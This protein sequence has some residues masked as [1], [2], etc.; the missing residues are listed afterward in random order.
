MAATLAEPASSTLDSVYLLYAGHNYDQAYAL[1]QRLQTAV[2]KPEERFN[3]L[4]ELGDYYLDKAGNYAAAESIYNQLVRDFPKHKLVP[5]LLYRLALAQE[6]QERHLD[7]ARNYEQVATKHMKSRFGTDALDAIERCFRKNY[8][9]RVAYVDGFPITRIEL[10]DRISRNPAAYEKFEQKQRLLDTMID[11]RLLYVAA[12]RAG[13]VAQPQFQSQ[14]NDVRNRLIFQEWYE[15]AVNQPSQ[16][17]ESEIRA[18]YR[19]NKKKYTIPERVHAYQILVATRPEALRLRSLLVSDTTI[20]WD[21]VARIHSLAPDKERGGDMGLFPRGVQPKPIEAVAFRLK[22]GEISQPI[23]VHDSFVIIKVVKKE[24]GRV[25]PFDEV[26]GQIE[27]DIRQTRAEK[28]YEQRVAELKATAVITQD[29]LAIVQNKETLAVVDGEPVTAAQVQVMLNN[30][31]PFYRSQFDTPEG[32]RRILDRIIMEKLLLRYCERNK[33]WLSNKVVDQ[34]LS[35]K[36]SML[37]DTYRRQMTTEKA[38]PDSA[39]LM[40]DYR[41][42]IQDFREPTRVVAREMVALTKAR[43]EQLRRWAMKGRIPAMVQGRAFVVPDSVQAWELRNQ[44]M[45]VTNIDSFISLGALAGL[46]SQLPGTPV[47]YLG[48]K[49]VSDLGQPCRLAGPYRASFYGFAFSDISTEDRLYQPELFLVQTPERFYELTQTRPPQPES[50]VAP[51]FDTLKFGTYVRLASPLP[52]EFV[53]GLFRLDSTGTSL[54]YRI[55]GG[56]L[57]VRVTKKDT[58]QKMAFADMIRRFSTSGSKWAG[59]ELRLTRDDK[60]R[61]KKVVDAAYSL[62]PGSYSPVIRLNDSTYTFILMEK[63]EPAY[64]RKFADVRGKIETKLRRE[65][66]KQLYDALISDLRAQAKIEIVMKES[67]FQTEEPT[68][69]QPIEQQTPKEEK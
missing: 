35:R 1:L 42:N 58:A 13:I 62:T 9:D 59:G 56:W 47:V 31:P 16:P 46:P 10:D 69:A 65:K 54:P 34:L 22:P 14:L 39:A 67:D 45:A 64:T 30:I 2:S 23:P 11:N 40:A 33:T 15:Q 36:S 26:K 68:E 25:R 63:K 32:K 12:L 8:Q 50:G 7:A 49:S 5:D 37:I 19:R 21:S 28:L 53:K 55:P 57:I 44:L 4:L 52:A 29:T 17:K 48:A 38:T 60:S 27:V 20:K 51:A 6:L 61:D 18:T 3:I 41:K 66:E 43:A 24:P